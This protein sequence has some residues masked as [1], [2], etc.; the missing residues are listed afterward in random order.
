MHLGGYTTY[1]SGKDFI[2][3]SANFQT[4]RKRTRKEV[5]N[6]TRKV[7]KTKVALALETVQNIWTTVQ[8][9]GHRLCLKWT[10]ASECSGVPL[11]TAPEALDHLFPEARDGTRLVLCYCCAQPM[12]MSQ[13][14]G[15]NMVCTVGDSPT[16]VAGFV[17]PPVGSATGCFVALKGRA[18]SSASAKGPEAYRRMI[19]CDVKAH[20]HH[21][22][23]YSAPQPPA[24]GQGFVQFTRTCSAIRGKVL[25]RKA[26]DVPLSNV[27]QTKGDI[28]YWLKCLKTQQLPEC[29]RDPDPTALS[30]FWA[31]WIWN[32]THYVFSCP[33][34]DDFPASIFGELV[35]HRFMYAGFHP[36]ARLP[37]FLYDETQWRDG[38]PQSEDEASPNMNM[39]CSVCELPRSAGPE[40][41]NCAS[42]GR[43]ALDGTHESG[44]VSSSRYRN[45]SLP[46]GMLSSCLSLQMFPASAE[47]VQVAES[48]SISW[49]LLSF[50]DC[51]VILLTVIITVVLAWV[52]RQ[53]FSDLIV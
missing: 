15:A 51:W 42:D 2:E 14:I 33:K 48:M 19:V 24:C 10:L 35:Y 18:G 29:V 44:V 7:A 30:A 1:L 41:Q 47:A 5:R 50:T 11:P 45:M 28:Q 52:L 40:C 6:Q 53:P 39:I 17:H 46:I 32:P 16:K 49:S 3:A 22:K 13:C 27:R 43:V 31:L 21:L 26:T 34:T 12:S 38:M 4:L 20:D 8:P 36:D 9:T 37:E 23:L 25:T